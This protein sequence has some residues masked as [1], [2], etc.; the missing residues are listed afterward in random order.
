M[1]KMVFSPLELKR[2]Y[3]QFESLFIFNF[4][5]MIRIYT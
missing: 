2:L 5:Q 4:I 1:E 3:L